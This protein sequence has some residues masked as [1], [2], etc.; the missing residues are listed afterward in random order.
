[1]MNWKADWKI[2]AVFVV[3][4]CGVILGMIFTS[5]NLAEYKKNG[6]CS[7]RGGSK[8][9]HISVGITIMK[10]GSMGVDT[11]GNIGIRTGG[12]IQVNP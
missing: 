2:G 5:Y 4:F 6:S 10:S 8:K 3:L 12:G 11:N 9:D 1:M 7:K